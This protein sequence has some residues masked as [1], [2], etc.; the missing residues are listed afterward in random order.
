MRICAECQENSHDFAVL[1]AVCGERLQ[2]R[3]ALAA[4]HDAEPRVVAYLPVEGPA[5]VIGRMDPSGGVFPDVDLARLV[6]LGVSAG[7]VS[8]RHCTV[9]RG[10]ADALTLAVEGETSGTQLNRTLVSDGGRVAISVGDRLVLGGR[11][12][13]KL[14]RI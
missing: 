2:G 5:C 9:L 6:P 11:V 7:H 8:R 13:L 1:C 3:L 12:R 10:T 4:Y 14:V